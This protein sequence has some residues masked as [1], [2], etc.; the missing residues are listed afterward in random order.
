MNEASLI[1]ECGINQLK[2]NKFT[3][4]NIFHIRKAFKE[5]T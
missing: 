5:I 4:P 2:F 1:Q 3:Q